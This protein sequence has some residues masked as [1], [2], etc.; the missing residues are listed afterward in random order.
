METNYLVSRLPLT[1]LTIP[2]DVEVDNVRFEFDGRNDDVERPRLLPIRVNEIVLRDQLEILSNRL[3]QRAVASLGQ[4]VTE[5][6]EDA[7]LVIEIA[8]RCL[9]FLRGVVR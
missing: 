9:V 3:E 5:I 6:A 4:I 7:V 2:H 1:C 8:F